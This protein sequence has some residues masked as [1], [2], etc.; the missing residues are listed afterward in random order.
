M[1]RNFVG[2]LGGQPR[3]L[4]AVRVAQR[5]RPA[6]PILCRV[7]GVQQLEAR[8]ALEGNSLRATVVGES[9]I[10]RVERLAMCCNPQRGGGR[11]IHQSIVAVRRM[12]RRRL[13][14]QDV[15]ADPTGRRIRAEVP[16]VRG[17]QGVDRADR[18]GRRALQCGFLRQ[19]AQGAE[20]PK[21]AIAGPTQPV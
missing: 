3:H 17:E 6:V 8:M 13:G 19:F 9:A 20:V 4:R 5:F 18:D 16:R 15:Q 12:Q 1:E 2:M 11:P 7:Q 10:M 21:A 14:V